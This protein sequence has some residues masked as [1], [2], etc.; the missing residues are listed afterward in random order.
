MIVQDA[1][2]TIF[3]A[4]TA[5]ELVE[6][7]RQSCDEAFDD[8][9]PD[10]MQEMADRCDEDC[11]DVIRTTT[12]EVFIADLIRTGHMRELSVH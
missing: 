10:F 4:E 3:R 6:Q 9:L 11:G 8:P 5:Y 2:G 7:M 12:P 1:V